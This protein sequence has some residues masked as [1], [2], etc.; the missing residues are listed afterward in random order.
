MVSALS[1]SLLQELLTLQEK[2]TIN[3]ILCFYINN[4]C[5]YNLLSNYLQRPYTK[6]RNIKQL[7]IND[8]KNTNLR[9]YLP[10]L[11]QNLLQLY[12]QNSELP[13]IPHLANSLHKQT[14]IYT[15]CFSRILFYVI[16]W[17]NHGIFPIPGIYWKV[18][19]LFS[20]VK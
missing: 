12:Q 17:M 9:I 6:P 14:N 5:Y 19:S 7:V 11:V 15:T 3:Q 8:H 10:L 13:F 2:K 16:V 18:Q 1:P 20:Y 4:N